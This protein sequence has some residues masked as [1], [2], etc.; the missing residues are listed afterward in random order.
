MAITLHS[1]YST[2]AYFIY[3]LLC[4]DT[5]H[6]LQFIPTLVLD[7]AL[8]ALASLLDAFSVACLDQALFGVL[9]SVTKSRVLAV[10][11]VEG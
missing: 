10:S 2:V 8:G 4:T 11:C 3:W 9:A 5:F 6:A 1:S 7:V